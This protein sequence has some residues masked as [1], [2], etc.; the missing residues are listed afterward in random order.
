MVSA[1]LAV[2]A[3]P[4]AKFSGDNPLSA[5]AGS[6]SPPPPA[7]S[8]RLPLGAVGAALILLGLLFVFGVPGVAALPRGMTLMTVATAL[9]FVVGGLGFLC[10]TFAVPLGV[11]MAGLVLVVAGVVGTLLGLTGAI[12]PLQDPAGLASPATGLS[13][14][15]FGAALLCM[16]RARPRLVTVVYCASL[17]LAASGFALL[18][19]ATGMRSTSSWWR[20]SSMPLHTAAGLAAAALTLFAWTVNALRQGER[21]VARSIPFFAAA[22]TTV[23]VLGAMLLAT[24]EH[25]RET[26]QSLIVVLELKAAITRYVTAMSRMDTTTRNFLLSGDE[27]YLQFGQT[28]RDEVRAA[29]ETLARLEEDNPTQAALV[30]TLPALSARKFASNDDQIRAM[31]EQGQAVAV[32]ALLNE[33]PDILKGMRS[34]NE[35]LTT[36]TERR[37]ARLRTEAAANEQTVRIG[38]LCGLLLTSG[39]LAIAFTSLSRAQIGL[40]TANNELESRVLALAASEERFRQA[41]ETAG[42]GIALVGIDGRWLRVNRTLAE[43]LGYTESELLMRTFQDITHKDDLEADL[44]HVG[45]LLDDKRRSYQMEKRYYRRDGQ[46]VWMRLSASLVRDLHG[47]PLHFVSHLEDIT[48]RKNL[49]VSLAAA[50]DQALEGSRM[51][52][53]FLATMSHEIRTPMNGVIGM[54]SLLRDTPLTA[55]QGEYV[56]TIESSGEALLAIINDIL[57]Y[58]KIEAGRIEL[59]VTSFDLRESIE[60]A[61]DL[62]AAKAMEKKLEL[63][64]L[65]GPEVPAEVE[66]DATRLR[67]ILVNLVGNAI[68]FTDKGEVIVT[69]EAEPINGRTRLHFGIKDTGIGIPPEGMSR[70]FKSFSQVDASTTRRF[71]GTGLGLAISRRLAE[72]MGGTMW[73]ESTPGEGATFHFTAM[74]D[75]R[76]QLVHHSLQRSHPDLKGK[77]L[78]VVDDH[79]PNRRFVCTLAVAWGMTVREAATAREAL[80]L[81]DQDTA[82][83]LA[84]LDMHMPEMDGAQLAA[85]IHR[86]PACAQLPLLLLTSLGERPRS[87]EFRL[88]MAKPIRAASLFK[89][90]RECL[91]AEPKRAALPP[92]P[93]T[94]DSTLGRRCPLRILIAEDNPVNQ[95]VANLMLRRLGYQAV[96][97]ANGLEVLTALQQQ[98]FD[99]ILMDIEMPELDGCEATRRIR[100]ANGNATSP[101]IV[102]LTAGV[103]Q[104]DRER[105]FAAG[106]NDYLA[107]PVHSDALSAALVKGYVALNLGKETT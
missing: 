106:L 102:A 104:H 103:M 59:E 76:P 67:Q 54:T 4:P 24:N 86:R 19:H 90:I 91:Q 40:Q 62:F 8:L 42:I 13:F 49:E 51:K 83:D 72:L 68:K 84:V 99:F 43:A 92:A 101:W 38:L 65:M 44:E 47:H 12:D 94:Y 53:E 79:E 33:P 31:R 93:P 20:Y 9:A 107:K 70:L 37:L 45:E 74:V 56:R 63:L 66:G 69:V 95:K 105:V 29:I 17:L 64:Y 48:D 23:L 82:C 98:E 22:G 52:S 15:L 28:Y 57:D 7:S 6:V 39:L 26:S 73:A 78:L 89:S 96:T 80:Q 60:D 30:K 77:K 16:V 14:A 61:L 87:P 75:A 35:A 36:D 10:C 71:G 18:E 97:V 50:R 3:P 32:K 81:L 2:I 5:Y 85:E 21:T 41:F 55:T 88:C 25:R 11:R 1:R 27:K 34:I 46:I 58:S 100:A